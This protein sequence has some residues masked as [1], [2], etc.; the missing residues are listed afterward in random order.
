MTFCLPI[1]SARG[2]ER[3]ELS[4]WDAVA[5]LAQPGE[6]AGA[7]ARWAA[8]EPAAAQAAAGAEMMAQPV[9]L[10]ESVLAQ[11]AAYFRLPVN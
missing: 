3:R 2:A 9:R 4:E 11:G 10:A 5:A 8:A 6:A 7:A 1:R